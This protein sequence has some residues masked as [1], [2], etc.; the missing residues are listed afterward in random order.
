MRREGRQTD[1]S[2]VLGDLIGSL[3]R[4]G[5]MLLQ[6]KVESSWNKVAGPTVSSHTTGAHLRAGQLV[7]SVDSA[8]W[9]N[10]LSA[11]S[12]H[13]LK[14]LEDDLGKGLINSIRFTV[15]PA[16]QREKRQQQEVCEH[17]A[18]YTEDVVE[19]IPLTKEERAQVEA[20]VASI[21]DE[22]LRQAVLRATV[23]DLEWKK[24]L[25]AHKRAQEP[26]QDS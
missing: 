15:A 3:D 9:A 7:V 13:Y 1:L 24:G 20:S 25:A 4:S 21:E 14:A 12:G 19:S 2:R 17:D 16:L 22:Q 23:A 5:A 18:F 8:I 6:V 10:E 26:P 11:L